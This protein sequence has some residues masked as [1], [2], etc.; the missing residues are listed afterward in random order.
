MRNSETNSE[1][2]YLLSPVADTEGNFYDSR[3]CDDNLPKDAD[4][5]GAYNIA[6]KGLWAVMKIKASKPQENLKLGISNKEWL[7]FAQEK[8]Y[9]ND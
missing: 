1:V 6:R 2:D 4:A 7:Q 9:L 3:N 8:P 5:N